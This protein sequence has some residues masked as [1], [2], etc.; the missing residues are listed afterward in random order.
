MRLNIRVIP[1]A[2]KQKI[3]KEE[4]RYKVYLNAP[5]VEGKANK[6]LIEFLAE[7]FK[8]KKR[9]IKIIRG[10]KGRDKTVEIENNG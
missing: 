2:K 4:N 1:N 9:Q 8:V 5:P 10:D 6:A 7:H 3:V